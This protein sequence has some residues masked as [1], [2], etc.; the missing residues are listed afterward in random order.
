[1]G[2]GCGLRIL[3][4]VVLGS[5]CVVACAVSSGVV[6]SPRAVL[7]W[8]EILVGQ[9]PWVKSGS[10]RVRAVRRAADVTTGPP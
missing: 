10:A 1:M 6:C 4:V 2:G 5:G 7:S 8:V 9:V 3:A